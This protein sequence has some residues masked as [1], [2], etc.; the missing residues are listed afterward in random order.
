MFPQVEGQENKKTL[1]TG[2]IKLVS[3][4]EKLRNNITKGSFGWVMFV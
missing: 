3:W 4:A 1:R 2:P